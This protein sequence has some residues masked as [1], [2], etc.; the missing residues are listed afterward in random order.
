L[1][2]EQLLEESFGIIFDLDGT[3]IDSKKQIIDAAQKTRLNNGLPNVD[4]A[5]IEERIGLPAQSLFEGSGDFGL[6][7]DRLV[8]DFRSE[9]KKIILLGTP[10]LPGVFDF[11]EKARAVGLPMAV[12]SNKS[13]ELVLLALKSAKLEIFFKHIQGTTEYPP[14]P[15][16][17][18]ILRC[19][20]VLG[21]SRVVMFGDRRE[22]M[23]S[24]N[25]ITGSFGVGI[26]T[27]AHSKDVLLSAG[28]ESAY[29]S[30]T[31]LLLCTKSSEVK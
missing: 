29:Q 18:I 30:F 25:Q 20:D 16:P 8:S 31:E 10:V 15:N 1:N 17:A 5:W 14:K 26:A 21:V 4:N 7:L 3:L 13:N 22:D 24:V 11:L 6:E 28:A 19:K 9:L 27:G 2:L 23:Q 12:A